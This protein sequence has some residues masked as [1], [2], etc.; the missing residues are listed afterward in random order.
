LVLKLGESMKLY[1]NPRCSKSRKTVEITENQQPEI[2]LYLNQPPTKGDLTSL[3]ERFDAPVEELVRWNDNDA[4]AKPEVITS[5]IILDILLKYPKYMQR[6][7]LDDGEIA[8]ICRPPERAY[9][10]I[11]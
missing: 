6:P 10:L 7:I 8:I 9:E 5:E 11:S 4:P 3:I 2:V 1:H